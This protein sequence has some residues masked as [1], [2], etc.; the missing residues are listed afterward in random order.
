MYCLLIMLFHPW[1]SSGGGHYMAWIYFPLHVTPGSFSLPVQETHSVH[2]SSYSSESTHTEPYAEAAADSSLP[3]PRWL[4]G[5]CWISPVLVM[6]CCMTCMVCPVPLCACW[7]CP[8][9]WACTICTCWPSPTCIVTGVVCIQNRA[10]AMQCSTATGGLL[11]SPTAPHW[12]FSHNKTHV[13]L[14]IKAS[15]TLYNNTMKRE[16]YFL[17]LQIASLWLSYPRDMPNIFKKT[18]AFQT[19]ISELWRLQ[20]PGVM[21]GT[22]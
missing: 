9:G 5:I 2:T 17:V 21:V 3:A 6:I 11:L 4:T 19:E 15:C 7:L 18:H 12:C 20:W 13:I 16:Y 22:W 8:C 14:A 10:E 1:G